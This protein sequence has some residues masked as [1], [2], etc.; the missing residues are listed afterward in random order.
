MFNEDGSPITLEKPIG[1]GRTGS[2]PF[3]DAVRP[4]S[5]RMLAEQDI[6]G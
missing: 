6:G 1:C 2:N 4:I 3:A 5:E